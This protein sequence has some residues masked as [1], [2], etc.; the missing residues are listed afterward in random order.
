MRVRRLAAT[1]RQLSRIPGAPLEYLRAEAHGKLGRPPR[2][3]TGN[4]ATPM[5]SASQ[6]EG[7]KIASGENELQHAITAQAPSN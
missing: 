4:A 7:R 1:A 3:R 5:H 6:G 2:G